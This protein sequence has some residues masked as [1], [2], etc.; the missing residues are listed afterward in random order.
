[1]NITNEDYAVNDPEDRTSQQPITILV[2]EDHDA[3]R[4]SLVD[5]MKDI[6]KDFT[7]LAARSGEEA[8]QIVSQQPP[9]IVIMDI[10]L[11]GMNG[12]RRIKQMNPQTQAVMLSMYNDHAF[13]EEAMKAGA[14]AY[15]N[16]H[17]MQVE[18][19]PTLIR[20][21]PANV[22]SQFNLHL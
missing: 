13:G 4:T 19:I 6:L 2:V 12:M 22:V 9:D 10:Q 5:W 1:M 7:F 21:L 15:I 11:P 14:C 18:L 16:K 20:L 8:V 3:L 17:N